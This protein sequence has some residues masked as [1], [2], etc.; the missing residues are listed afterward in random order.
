MDRQTQAEDDHRRAEH[1]RETSTTQVVPEPVT[2][3]VAT[4]ES[5][6]ITDLTVSSLAFRLYC[7]YRHRA[8]TDG[9]TAPTEADLCMTLN[10]SRSTLFRARNELE[11]AGWVNVHRKGQR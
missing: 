5:W 9:I 11:H 3:S 4:I 1:H 8:G 6:R 7:L 2:L 10:V